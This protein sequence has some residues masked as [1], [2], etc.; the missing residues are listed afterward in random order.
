M[1]RCLCGKEIPKTVKVERSKLI[2]EQAK[3]LKSE[4]TSLATLIFKLGPRQV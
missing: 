2:L 1:E 3:N 4:S